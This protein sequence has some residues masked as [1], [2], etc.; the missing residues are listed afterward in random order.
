MLSVTREDDDGS[1]Q[2][3]EADFADLTDACDFALGIADVL[4]RENVTKGGRARWVHV[5]RDG[6]TEL[7]IA[8]IR[9]GLAARFL[10]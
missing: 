4:D 5:I 7:T 6:R 3:I 2:E 9:G 8:I 1:T 10:Q